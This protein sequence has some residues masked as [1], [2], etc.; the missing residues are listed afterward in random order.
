MAFGFSGSET[1]ARMEGGDVALVYMDGALGYALD[2]N[3]TAKSSVFNFAI[4]LLNGSIY[5][6]NLVLDSALAFWE[7]TEAFVGMINSAD[8]I[9]INFLWPRVLMD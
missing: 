2:Y 7:R 3:I 4:L 1:E 6:W 5:K 9:I 8:R